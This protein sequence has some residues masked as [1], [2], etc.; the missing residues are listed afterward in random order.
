MATAL[1]ADVGPEH[2]GHAAASETDLSVV[3]PSFN[4]ELRLPHALIEMIDWLDSRG[5]AYE[6][7]VVDDGS[8]DGTSVTVR[9]FA[10]IRPQVR[11][12]R[13]PVNRGKGHAVRTGALNSVGRRVLFA[14]ADGATPFAELERLED[15]IASGADVAIGSRAAPGSG[16]R[17]RSDPLRKFVGRVF[18]AWVSATLLP[19]ISDTQCGFKLFTRRA[20]DFLFSRQESE[21]FSFDVEILYIARR[22]GMHVREVPVNWTSMPGSKVSL[23]R[24]ASRML[25]DVPR[26]RWKHRDIRPGSLRAE[27]VP[28]GT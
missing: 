21:R 20:A 3:V 8:R 7:I 19:G 4:E 15:A 16:T 6:I 1:L 14:D 10:R 26:F 11:L 9:Q 13:L 24:D 22:A 27:Q 28:A 5:T 17:V 18:N 2:A 12:I 25:L 23:L